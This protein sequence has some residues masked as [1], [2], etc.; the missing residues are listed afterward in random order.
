MRRARLALKNGIPFALA[1]LLVAR[2]VASDAVA[3]Y[4]NPT[5]KTISA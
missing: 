3:D 2:G 4:L 5:L 1:R